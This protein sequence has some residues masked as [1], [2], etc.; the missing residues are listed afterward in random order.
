MSA[1]IDVAERL[2]STAVS[3][4]EPAKDFV[5]ARLPDVNSADG[6]EIL[7]GPTYA[8]LASEGTITGLD[9]EG[10]VTGSD[11]VCD[12]SDL[13]V[14][15]GLPPVTE[16]PGDKPSL[17]EIVLGLGIVRVFERVPHVM[18]RLSE[19]N[20]ENLE[21]PRVVL[22][23]GIVAELGQGGY[24]GKVRRLSQVLL[25]ASHLNMKLK[26]VDLRFGR[27]VIVEC[28]KNP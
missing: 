22:S 23:G 9:R 13:P 15:T 25:Q 19:I 11:T 17:P 2:V 20:L 10:R 16:E 14:L 1:W 6:E 4:L 12:L 8:L 24:G 26:R 27:Q 28:D 7:P 5:E 3:H 18:G 21:Q